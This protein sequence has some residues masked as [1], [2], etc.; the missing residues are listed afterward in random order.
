MKTQFHFKSIILR[1]RQKE[2][3]WLS[4][5]VS[6][7]FPL[8]PQNYTKKCNSVTLWKKGEFERNSRLHFWLHFLLDIK[9]KCNQLRGSIGYKFKIDGYK[10]LPKH[11]VTVTA[12]I[13]NQLFQ[14]SYWLHNY[15]I[16]VHIWKHERYLAHFSKSVN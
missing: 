5:A 10:F 4:L 16:L 12:L 9:K 15:K 8:Q 2:T 13:Y 11:F 14:K 3:F 1:K 7:L 6:P